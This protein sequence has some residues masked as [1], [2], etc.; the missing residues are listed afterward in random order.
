MMWQADDPSG[1]LIEIGFG[2]QVENVWK[3]LNKE[4]IA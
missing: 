2:I 3:F 4:R 1:P